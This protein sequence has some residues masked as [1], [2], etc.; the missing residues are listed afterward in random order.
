[1]PTS[2]EALTPGLFS[3][4]DERLGDT[5]TMTP[6]SPATPV[7]FPANVDFGETRTDFGGSAINVQAMTVDI[8]RAR[9]PGKPAA[10]WRLSSTMLP[11]RVFNPI[12]VRLD[13]SGLRWVFGLKEVRGG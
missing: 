5:I 10:S 8:D 3:A 1:M 11:D 2:L 12:D 7:T 4:C 13:E 6:P 9:V